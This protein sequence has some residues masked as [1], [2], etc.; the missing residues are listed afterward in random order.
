MCTALMA[1]AAWSVTGLPPALGAPLQATAAADVL[2]EADRAKS[3][4]K[5]NPG[6]ELAVDRQD[7]GPDR[8]LHRLTGSSGETLAT[9][10]LKARERGASHPPGRS[11]KSRSDRTSSLPPPFEGSGFVDWSRPGPSFLPPG[12][13]VSDG[14]ADGSPLAPVPVPPALPVLAAAFFALVIARRHA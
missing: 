13:T 1:V 4:R 14:G 6:F 9:E 12:L 3:Q 7:E 10:N 5:P 2:S 11:E 8:R